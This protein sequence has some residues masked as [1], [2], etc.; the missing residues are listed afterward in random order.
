[1]LKLAAIAPLFSATMI[2]RWLKSVD[3]IIPYA[4]I[5]A[6]MTPDEPL[7]IRRDFRRLLSFIEASALL[8]QLQREVI[9]EGDLTYVEA[10][11]S[12]Y[13]NAKVLLEEIFFGTLYGVHSNTRILMDGIRTLIEKTITRVGGELVSTKELMD[14]LNWTK[15]K[16]SRWA[17]PLKDYDWIEDKDRGYKKYYKV[18]KELEGASSVLLSVEELAERFPV[19]AKDFKAVHPITGEVLE[20]SSDDNFSYME[21]RNGETVG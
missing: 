8:H 7:R 15:S 19:L 9:Q 1:M 3:V 13:F 6:D 16:I 10:N 4:S 18:G 14:H 21:Q 20:L 2:I 5:L 17:K 12:D 11:L